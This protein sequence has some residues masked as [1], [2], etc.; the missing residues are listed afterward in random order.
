MC[1]SL[2]KSP[3]TYSIT[4]LPNRTFPF[5]PAVCEVIEMTARRYTAWA[6][7]IPGYKLI[8]N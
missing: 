5:F 2:I 6:V 4:V 1:N 7:Q 8:S 3:P